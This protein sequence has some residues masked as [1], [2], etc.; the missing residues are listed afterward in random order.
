MF[1]EFLLR[2]MVKSQLKD[3]PEAEQEKLV[4]LISENPQLFQNIAEEV[5]AKVKGGMD[6]MTA[7]LEVMTK[8]KDDLQK[9]MPKQ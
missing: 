8:Y 3:V 5:Q 6:Q 4:T 2:K 7:M 1:K 9:V